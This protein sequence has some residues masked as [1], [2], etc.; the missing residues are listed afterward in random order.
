MVAIFCVLFKRRDSLYDRSFPSSFGPWYQNEVRCSAF[1]MKV[2]FHSHAKVTYFL[3][4]VCAFGLI[5][6]ARVFGTRNWPLGL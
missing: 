3:E 4:K 2:I 6:E 5:L 1:D